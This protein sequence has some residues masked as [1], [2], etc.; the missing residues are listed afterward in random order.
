MVCPSFHCNCFTYDENTCKPR[1]IRHNSYCF[2]MSIKLK[3]GTQNPFW[4]EELDIIE[5]LNA[6]KQEV[7]TTSIHRQLKLVKVYVRAINQSDVNL[8]DYL[9]Y[10]STIYRPN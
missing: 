9:I 6:V 4:V 10:S 3:F 8:V 2:V 7:T 5:I 1:K